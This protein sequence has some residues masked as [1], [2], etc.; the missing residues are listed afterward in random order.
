MLLDDL[1]MLSFRILVYHGLDWD[2]VA[3]LSVILPLFLVFVLVYLISSC[4]FSRVL[5]YVF[6]CLLDCYFLAFV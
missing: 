3:R 5:V 4:L 1:V 2:L 6:D